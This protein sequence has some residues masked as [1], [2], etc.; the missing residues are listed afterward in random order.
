MKFRLNIFVSTELFCVYDFQL[1]THILLLTSF[2]SRIAIF[3]ETPID[4][5]AS[6]THT[7]SESE[8][9]RK[10]ERNNRRNKKKRNN[11]Q[12]SVPICVIYIVAHA[13]FLLQPNNTLSH[14]N[15]RNPWKSNVNVI[16]MYIHY[17]AMSVSVALRE[18]GFPKRNINKLYCTFS[19]LP[20]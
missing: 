6:N 2:F 20:I 15:M 13:F 16:V 8:R 1:Y 14:P 19:L 4:A 12:I 5:R 11:H 10:K 18:R 3:S 7:H 9:K 17:N